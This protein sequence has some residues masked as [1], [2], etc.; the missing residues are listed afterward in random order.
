MSS[1][2][3][4][5]VPRSDFAR[6]TAGLANDPGSRTTRV[7]A[8]G[9]TR[10]L[11]GNAERVPLAGRWGESRARYRKNTC[12]ATAANT[13]TIHG[14]SFHSA[15]SANVATTSAKSA[16]RATALVHTGV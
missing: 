2:R 8:D 12:A 9:G 1:R 4:E 15:S 13:T 14:G 6:T 11:S 7:G 10:T 16:G 3:A 5:R